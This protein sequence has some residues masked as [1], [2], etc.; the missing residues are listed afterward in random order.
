M[1]KRNP[2]SKMQKGD[3]VYAQD[4]MQLKCFRVVRV[5]A[6]GNLTLAPLQH[7]LN[8]TRLSSGLSSHHTMTVVDSVATCERKVT[9]RL[10][11]HWKDWWA[12]WSDGSRKSRGLVYKLDSS[13]VA[14]RI[15]EPNAMVKAWTVKYQVTWND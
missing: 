7:T 8:H 14:T 5:T 11:K 1:A 6:K 10:D 4:G 15:D 9:A 2:S 13:S 12:S 3:A